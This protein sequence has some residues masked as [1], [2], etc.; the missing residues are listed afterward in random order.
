MIKRLCLVVV[1]CL[2]AHVVGYAQQFAAKTNLLYDATATINLGVEAA[3]SEQWTMDIS[4]NYNAWVL[5]ED[6]RFKHWFVQPEIRY[7]L[8]DNFSGHF[9]GLHGILG[10]YN[11]GGLQNDLTILGVDFSPLSDYRFQ[12]WG[13]GAGIAY[14]YDWILGRHMNL[15]AEI[16]AGIIYTE[17]DQFKCVGCGKKVL[18]GQ[19]YYYVGLTKAALSLVYIF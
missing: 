14:G 5:D 9:F 7:W 6:V 12:G 13:T 3:V 2:V 19:P 4:G 10:Q 15:E 16:G 11:F 8:C 17:Y 18:S 1:F